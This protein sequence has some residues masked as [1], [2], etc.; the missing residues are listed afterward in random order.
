MQ[1]LHDSNK[2]SHEGRETV[3]AAYLILKLPANR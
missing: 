3:K 2:V 1:N